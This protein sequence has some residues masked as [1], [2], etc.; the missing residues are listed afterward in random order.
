LLDSQFNRLRMHSSDAWFFFDFDSIEPLN[1]LK[2]AAHAVW[3]VR[4]ATGIDVSAPLLCDLS[5][6]SSDETGLSG[7]AAFSKILSAYDQPKNK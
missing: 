5:K 3:L 4:S 2:Y 7:D 6:A 1:G